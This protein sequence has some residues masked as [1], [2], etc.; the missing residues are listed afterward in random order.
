MPEFRAY[1]IG[2]DGRFLNIRNFAAASDEE[3]IQRVQ[4]R[5]LDGQH[6]VELWQDAQSR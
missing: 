6:K 1:V 5:Y 2:P 4:E 3:A